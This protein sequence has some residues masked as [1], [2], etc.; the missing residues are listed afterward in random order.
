M[1]SKSLKDSIPPLTIVQQKKEPPSFD[2]R[3]VFM[4]DLTNMSGH[5]LAIHIP[6]GT[7]FVHFH[8]SDFE[9]VLDV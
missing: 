2:N 5:C 1:P 4:G 9:I 6:T 7:S 8:S 3:F